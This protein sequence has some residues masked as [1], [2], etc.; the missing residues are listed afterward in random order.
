MKKKKCLSL[1]FCFLKPSSPN[2]QAAAP[3]GWVVFQLDPAVWN[4]FS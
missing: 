2:L 3:S 4:C 1:F